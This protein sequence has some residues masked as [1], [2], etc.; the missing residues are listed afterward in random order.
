[1]D[2]NLLLASSVETFEMCGVRCPE[3]WKI[4]SSS[5][6]GLFLLIFLIKYSNNFAK[7]HPFIGL[8]FAKILLYCTKKL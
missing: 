8:S 4:P 6:F 3:K 1:M 5:N 2:P 7:Y